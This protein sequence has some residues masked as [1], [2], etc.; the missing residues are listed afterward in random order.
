M[1]YTALYRKYRSQTFDDLVGQEHII[2]T[3]RQAVDQGK[4]SH[5]YLFTGPRGTGK[6]STARLLAK[7]LN[8][9]DGP[10]SSPPE[11]DPICVEI[12]QGS[13]MDVIEM[14]AASESGVDNIRRAVVDASSYQP[15]Y[16]R[17]KIFIIDEVHDLS[18]SAF[19]ALLKTIE[20][21][22]PHVVFILATTELQKVPP[23]IRSRCQRYEFHRGS[24]ENLVS[25]LQFVAES[26]G[27]EIEQAALT[28]L[29]RMAD[30]G[31]RDALTLLEQAILTAE[32]PITLNQVYEQLGLIAAD[33]V[34]RL[35]EA[36][37]AKDI[38]EI[39]AKLDEVFR[40]GRDAEAVVESLTYRLADLTRTLFGVES[41]GGK[42]VTQE[43]AAEAMARRL[44]MDRILFYRAAMAQFL[45][46]VG[47]VTLPRHWIESEMVRLAMSPVPSSTTP[48]H[49]PE[50]EAEVR[51]ERPAALRQDLKPARNPEPEVKAA[52]VT[53]REEPKPEPETHAQ[54]EPEPE[55]QPE[56]A[57][58]ATGR[59]LEQ[60][61][62]IWRRVV[63]H[64]SEKN[65]KARAW[66]AGTELVRINGNE[67]TVE[68]PKVITLQRYMEK[69]KAV[70]AVEETAR[71]WAKSVIMFQY[72]SRS[73][74]GPEADI[75]P[76]VPTRAVESVFEGDQLVEEIQREFGRSES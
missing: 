27:V 30:G 10:M 42:D 63:A 40:R 47:H 43:A 41:K 5:A 6:T 58:V 29:A 32:G 62:E 19:D 74:G 9:T 68:F 1:S 56:V 48:R 8:C 28:A 39:H 44:G 75:T 65:D 73:E 72:E 14:D 64:W 33:E 59:T 37:M 36:L 54:P 15:A 60:A 55:A 2:R 7:A 12:A 67:W 46:S 52:V 24:L 17:Y 16:C 69:P 4:I 26:E 21:P 50:M 70:A 71:E 11:D 53:P 49:A 38:A 18:A 22:P 66:L 20:E 61:Q 76:I 31:Y 3:L 13:C 25:R 45:A 51:R 23:T 34:D 35:L 57:P